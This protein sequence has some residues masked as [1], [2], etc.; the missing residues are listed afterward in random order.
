MQRVT[1]AS[2]AHAE[3]SAAACQELHSQARSMEALVVDLRCL[4]GGAS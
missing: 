3:E 4:V 1:Q 2:A